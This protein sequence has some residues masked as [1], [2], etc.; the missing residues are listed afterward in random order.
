MIKVPKLLTLLCRLR[1]SALKAVVKNVLKSSILILCWNFSA[2]QSTDSLT[3]FNYGKI[4]NP[5]ATAPSD[6]LVP[7]AVSDG[8]AINYA[9]SIEIIM[10]CNAT[11]SRITREVS[12]TAQVGLAAFGG[13]G[14][15]Y[16]WSKTTLT[17]LGLG[18]AAI[19]QLQGIFD[20]KGRAEAYNQAA[21]MI[22]DGVLEYYAHNPEPSPSEF[23]PNGL[24]LVKKVATAI[25]LVNDTITGHLPSQKDMQNAVEPMSP[26]GTTVQNPQAPPVNA[27]HSAQSLPTRFEGPI[28]SRKVIIPEGPTPDAPTVG[29]RNKLRRLINKLTEPD[30][31]AMLA[32]GRVHADLNSQFARTPRNESPA[33]NY[34]FRLIET[35]DDNELSVWG[36][37]IP[38]RP[39]VAAT[40]TPTEPSPHQ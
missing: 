3:L 36:S 23:T 13:L 30:A 17:V 25:N 7:P 16:N 38:V 22:Q 20:A 32:A 15:A 2:C 9:N 6:P 1:R 8:L 4:P 28:T 31:E 27:A 14:A 19:P 39:A 37:I 40:P 26:E 5:G 35:A 34:L 12:A 10:R 24:T 21:E 33:R 11:R 18:S 29:K